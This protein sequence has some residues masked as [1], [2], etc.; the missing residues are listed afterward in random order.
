MKSGDALLTALGLVSRLRCSPQSLLFP[1]PGCERR[2]RVRRLALPTIDLR[3]KLFGRQAAVLPSLDPLCPLLSTHS[4]ERHLRRA[5]HQVSNAECR[6]DTLHAQGS[7][8]FHHAPAIVGD[9]LR[10][11][12]F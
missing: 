7:D 8:H 4:H 11:I 5:P 3:A 9:H 12:G 10:S 6:T 1:P 2:E